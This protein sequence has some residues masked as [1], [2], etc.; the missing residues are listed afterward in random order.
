MRPDETITW[1][2]NYLALLGQDQLVGLGNAQ[3][4]GAARMLDQYL[5]RLTEQLLRMQH[6]LLEGRTLHNARCLAPLSLLGRSA[7]CAH[8][9]GGDRHLRAM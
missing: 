2:L 8:R 1:L 3:S 7:C 9:F 6:A 5:V 4:I